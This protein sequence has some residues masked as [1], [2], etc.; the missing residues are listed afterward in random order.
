LQ[1]CKEDFA[2]GEDEHYRKA[3]DY[4]ASELRRDNTRELRLEPATLVKLAGLWFFIS[5]V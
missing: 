4:V 1:L 2:A 5:E 3:V